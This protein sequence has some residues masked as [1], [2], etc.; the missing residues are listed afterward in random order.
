MTYSWIN[1]DSFIHVITPNAMLTLRPPH[2][3]G[4]KSE[5]AK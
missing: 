5:K 4:A 1:L 3:K 2:V